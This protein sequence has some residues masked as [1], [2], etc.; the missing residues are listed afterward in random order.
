MNTIEKNY[1]KYVTDT[2]E[3][4][5]EI[6][7]FSRTFASVFVRSVAEVFVRELML[8][9]DKAVVIATNIKVKTKGFVKD[10]EERQL[11]VNLANQIAFLII[12]TTKSF[13][14]NDHYDLE[15]MKNVSSGISVDINLAD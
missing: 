10:D 13:F 6:F 2:I 15:V 12:T 7:D 1:I 3:E 8:P 4:Q 9:Y 5:N 14:D 11:V